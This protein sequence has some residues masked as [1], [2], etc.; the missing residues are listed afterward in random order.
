MQGSLLDDRWNNAM[1]PETP[2]LIQ[3]NGNHV[4]DADQTLRYVTRV[5]WRRQPS[6]IRAVHLPRQMQA[7]RSRD[8]GQFASDVP[9]KTDRLPRVNSAIP[10]RSRALVSATILAW[11]TH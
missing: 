11:W 6:L 8:D 10:S 3:I 2:A 1:K 7:Y 4:F 5:F 9:K